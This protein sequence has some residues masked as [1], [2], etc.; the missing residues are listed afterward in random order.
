MA[1]SFLTKY[2]IKFSRSLNEVFEMI[3]VG[4]YSVLSKM[5]Y[6][7]KIII[8]N[9]SNFKKRVSIPRWESF[10]INMIYKIF[11]WNKILFVD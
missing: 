9:C 5:V 10:R 3:I 2:V 6:Q 4:F 7:L 1:F 8:L 11:L